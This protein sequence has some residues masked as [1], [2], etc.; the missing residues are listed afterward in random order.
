MYFT[1]SVKANSF[2]IETDYVYN[3]SKLVTLPI[4]CYLLHRATQP[5]EPENPHGSSGSETIWIPILVG[6]LVLFAIFVLSIV[7]Y[8][9]KFI[10]LNLKPILSCVFL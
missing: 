7:I 9:R 3:Y 10:L 2:Y 1:Y 4:I 8:K 5:T 6:T